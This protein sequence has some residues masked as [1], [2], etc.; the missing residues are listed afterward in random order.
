MLGIGKHGVINQFTKTTVYAFLLSLPSIYARVNVCVAVADVVRYNR[1]L[2]D[3]RCNDV[4][5]FMYTAT[6]RGSR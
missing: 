2:C 1:R 6:P 4:F 5:N 3:F